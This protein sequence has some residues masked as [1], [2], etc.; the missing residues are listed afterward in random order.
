MI[1]GSLN[2]G[3]VKLSLHSDSRLVP[4][5]SVPEVVKA[6]PTRTSPSRS[7]QCS[8]KGPSRCVSAHLCLKEKESGSA[9][10]VRASVWIQ[11]A[12]LPM[13][14]EK[15]E[16]LKIIICGAPASGKGTQCELIVQ[17]YGLVHISAG[18]LLR[19]EVDSGTENGRRAKEYMERGSLVPD[20]IIVTVLLIYVYFNKCLVAFSPSFNSTI[21][22][23]VL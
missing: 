12:T 19:A 2:V 8:R 9:S 7:W 3:A 17:K 22:W 14:S 15:E 21:V 4:L 16:P 13:S 20:E 11:A 10:K 5:P 18:D 6:N 1:M 23:R